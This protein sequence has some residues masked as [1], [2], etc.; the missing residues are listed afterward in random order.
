M[1]QKR[2][3]KTVVR[4]VQTEPENFL[5]AIHIDTADTDHQDSSWMTATNLNERILTFKTD[6]G[7]DVTVI[8]E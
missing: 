8:S 3:L 6:T 1:Q 4:E 5:G 7:T 2:P